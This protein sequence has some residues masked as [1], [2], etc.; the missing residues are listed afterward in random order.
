[1]A[2]G[3]SDRLRSTFNV[4]GKG[5][6]IGPSH[7]PL[8]PKA[9]GFDVE[10]LDYLDAEGLREK[11][12]RAGL[13]V[14]AVEEVDFIGDG[15]SMTEV[16]GT[17]ARY[18]WIVAS[19]VI[20]HVPDLVSF[21]TD[22]EALLKPGGSLVLAVPDKRCCFDILRP[23]STVGQVLQ[24]HVDGRKRPSPGIVFDDVAY[25]RKRDGH[26]GW[27]LADRGE[28]K[29]VRPA[30]DAWTLFEQAR[31][32]DAYIDMHCWVFVPSS[33][34]LIVDAL[35][36][37]G[38]IGLRELS[39]Q[40]NDGEFFV[41]LST[42]APLTTLDIGALALAAV[43]EEREALVLAETES[44]RRDLEATRAELSAALQ[45]QATEAQRIADIT[46][47]T[48]WRLTAP[49]RAAKNLVAKTFH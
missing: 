2:K 42:S 24:A 27:S 30:K 29:E 16:I 13:D 14:S 37:F 39:F 36:T 45:R 8:M 10:I 23:I 47:S 40:V 11:Y 44:L 49:L 43:A 15:R 5:L 32:S 6:E 46:A 19:H 4:A 25:A 21:L 28:L 48:S 33:F 26:I 3:R 22:C 17:H 41:V 18:D 12:A 20:E 34:R 7:S 38:L 35:A 1:M 9:A 31:R